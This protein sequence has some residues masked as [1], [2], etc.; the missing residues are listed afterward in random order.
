MKRFS[1]FFENFNREF[2][3]L[4]MELIKIWLQIRTRRPLIRFYAN[5]G[6]FGCIISLKNKQLAC[7][8]VTLYGI[9]KSALNRLT[10]AETEPIHFFPLLIPF[11]WQSMKTIN[12]VISHSIWNMKF[13]NEFQKLVDSSLMSLKWPSNIFSPLHFTFHIYGRQNGVE[14]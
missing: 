13:Q 4:G 9:L 14:K 1:P 6:K 10:W 2:G 12:F 8:F 7:F 5:F 11:F 3:T